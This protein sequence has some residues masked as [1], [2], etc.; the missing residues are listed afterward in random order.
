MDD[1]GILSLLLHHARDDSQWDFQ[2]CRM[3]FKKSGLLH[4]SLPDKPVFL[5]EGIHSLEA[6]KFLVSE[7]EPRLVRTCNVKG[8]LLRDTILHLKMNLKR[9][10]EAQC[11]RQVEEINQSTY[12]KMIAQTHP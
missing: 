12:F 11:Y 6:W 3:G 2:S 10:K 1:Y 8:K 9:H 4:H 5:E 7:I